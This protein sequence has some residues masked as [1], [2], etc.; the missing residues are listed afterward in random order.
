MFYL[1][2]NRYIFKAHNFVVAAE[3][4]TKDFRQRA[5]QAGFFFSDSGPMQV[6]MQRK[7]KDRIIE[8]ICDISEAGCSGCS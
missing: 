7:E 4:T 1:P 8:K 5:D 2:W 3:E 6:L